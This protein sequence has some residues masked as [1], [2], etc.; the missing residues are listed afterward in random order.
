MTVTARQEELTELLA[1]YAKE[2][3]EKDDPS[4]SDAEY[5]RLYDELQVLEEISGVILP[6]SPSN[7]VGGKPQEAFTPHTH[8]QRLWSLAKAQTQQSVFDWTNRTQKSLSLNPWYTVEEKMDGLSLCLTYQN[9]RLV[10]AATRGDGKIGEEITEQAR[11]IKDIPQ[12]IRYLG[13]V[14]VQGE[15][16]MRKSVLEAYNLVADVPLKNTRNGA[17]GALRNLDPQQTKKR[18]LN[19]VFYNVGETDADLH[20]VDHAQMIGFLREN[21]FQTGKFTVCINEDEVWQ[22]ILQVQATRNTLDYDIDGAVVK[23]YDLAQR[24][25]LG[26][27][28]KFPRGAIAYK[29]EAEETTTILMDVTW[30]VG[31][32]GRITPLAHVEQ[33]TLSGAKVQRATL[34]NIEDIRR[35]GVRL[36]AR[37]FI[38]RSNDVIPEIT[39]IAGDA[40]QGQQILP[41]QNCPACGTLLIQTG[42]LLYCPNGL[43]C[44]PQLVGRIVHYASRKA[45]DIEGLSDKTA[46]MLVSKM[47]VKNLVDLYQLNADDL[48]MQEGFG[49]KKAGALIKALQDTKTCS[50]DRFLFGLGIPNIGSATARGIAAHIGSIKNLFNVDAEGLATIEDVGSVV[51]QGVV[52]YLRQDEVVD[53]INGLLACGVKPSDAKK[54]TGSLL[55]GKTLVVTGTLQSMDRTMAENTIRRLGGIASGSVSKNTFAVIAGESAGSKKQKAIALQVPVWDEETFMTYIRQAEEGETS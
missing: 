2:Y 35:K 3:Y 36:G 38:R 29:F 47:G 30:E 22:A 20:F 5:D 6:L 49:T 16:Y 46:E 32:T 26:F 10:C 43:H 42:P 34:N 13:F 31:R 8:V 33:V 12:T 23:V 11:T 50:L 44:Q 45:M 1:Q 19:T 9:G 37:V 41:P 27:T 55:A 14:E 52:D 15:C 21:G 28:D 24:Q 7:K 54:N 51:S 18:N 4:I 48:A 40:T 53:E 17:A 39:G 25:S